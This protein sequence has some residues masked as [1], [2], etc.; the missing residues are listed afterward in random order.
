MYKLINWGYLH[1]INKVKVPNVTI[2]VHPITPPPAP[3]LGRRVTTDLPSVSMTQQVAGGWSGVAMHSN[4]KHWPQ[5]LV[6]PSPHEQLLTHQ[7]MQC[8]LCPPIYSYWVNRI[9]WGD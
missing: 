5:D 3:L 1:I 8:K 6:A 4:A 2:L 7:V 9:G